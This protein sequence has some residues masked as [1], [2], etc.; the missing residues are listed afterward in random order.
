[1][2]FEPLPLETD[3]DAVALRLLA[4]VR[5][6][7]AAQGVTYEPSEGALDTAILAEIGRETA[8]TNARTIEAA[9][10][11]FAGFGVTAVGLPIITAA[12]ATIPVTLTVTAAGV[13]VPAGLQ[14]LGI[15]DNSDPVA[16]QLLTAVT[17]ASTTVL[18]SM[19]ALEPGVAGNDVPTG[20]LLVTTASP[21]VVSA[22]ATG[23]STGGV[24]AESADDYTGRLSDYMATLG[25][26]AVR[27]DDVVQVARSAGG[28]Q[29]ALAI[30][31]YDATTG[32]S[33]VERT[34][35]V[36]PVD[37]TGG[38]I[39]SDA[40]TRLQAALEAVR[41]VNFIF[42]VADPTYT[43]LAI[44]F[45]AVARKGYD[46]PTVQAACIQALTDYLSPRAWGASDLATPVDWTARNIV[47][48]DDL[49]GALYAAV[50]GLGYLQTLTINGGTA[51]VTLPG[52]AALPKSTTAPSTPTTITG[53]VSA[54]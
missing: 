35:S 17:A 21:V 13:V 42:R 29:R 30:D 18:V 36:F 5:A 32:Q 14:V 31:L 40:R 20:P 39:S 28:V 26:Q 15:N 48:R 22:V 38:T 53:T 1:M 27:A 37:A 50:D 47:R 33:N 45:T 10:A 7:L 41:E 49:V 19:T 6:R 52:V 9:Q 34:V 12:R 8:L 11:A 44:N 54:P 25:P 24:D 46:A 2:A 51:N 3:E 23:I 43:A 16:F 4:G